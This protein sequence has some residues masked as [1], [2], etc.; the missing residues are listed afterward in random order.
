MNKKTYKNYCMHSD[1]PV[2]LYVLAV[3][4]IL[5]RFNADPDPRI[6]WPKVEKFVNLKSEYF[7]DQKLQC[8]CNIYSYAFMKDV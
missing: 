2:Y 8:R 6:W 7:S 4:G 3:L 5:I 1:V